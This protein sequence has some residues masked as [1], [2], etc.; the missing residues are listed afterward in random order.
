MRA[1]SAPRLK[2]GFLMNPLE[3]WDFDGDTSLS[4]ITE[5]H[6][7]GHSLCFFEARDLQLRPPSVRARVRPCVPD[8]RTGLAT[9]PPRWMDLASLDC[10]FIRK[11][12]PF[13]FGYL[14]CTYILDFLQSKTLLINSPRGIRNTNEKLS[15]LLSRRRVRSAAGYTKDTLVPFLKS[16]KGPAV[17]KRIDEKGG[18]GILKSSAEDPGLL[19]KI[20][21]LSVDGTRAVL[22]QEFIPHSKTGDKRILILDGKPIGAFLRF[23]PKRDFR[24]NMSVGGTAGPG[25]VS[26]SDRALVRSLAPYFCRNGLHFVGIDILDGRLSEINVTSPAGIPEINGF[27]GTRLERDVADFIER[28]SRAGRSRRLRRDNPERF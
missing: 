1:R 16:L 5:C 19:K 21:E 27:D 14:S 2:I 11:E 6:R 12:P 9:E 13:D 7:R 23:P 28:N 8:S 10:L 17:L 24:A 20:S 18:V 26:R 22:A 4:I 25:Q 3:G 15:S